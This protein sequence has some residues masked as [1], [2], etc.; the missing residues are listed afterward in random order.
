MQKSPLHP[1]KTL[2]EIEKFI[3]VPTAVDFFIL[4]TYVSKAN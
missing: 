3:F 4:K 2:K 1:K